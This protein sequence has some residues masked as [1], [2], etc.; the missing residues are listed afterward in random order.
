MS[1]TVS[2]IQITNPEVLQIQPRAGGAVPIISPEFKT[3]TTIKIPE[4]TRPSTIEENMSREFRV[5]TA[6]DETESLES[7][8]ATL[9][10]PLKDA[11]YMFSVSI[12]SLIMMA[13]GHASMTQEYAEWT[14]KCLECVRDDFG[15][16]P[17]NVQGIL[18]HINYLQKNGQLGQ[19]TAN[20]GGKTTADERVASDTEGEGNEP[21]EE[22][23]NEDK[24]IKTTTR[25]RLGSADG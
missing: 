7:Q 10:N 15:N 12:S 13:A 14:K 4:E 21:T 25:L 17:P 9:P 8:E 3:A 2:F 5:Q 1:E 18:N 23:N 20:S 24:T 16:H 22:D 6:L 19:P 11:M